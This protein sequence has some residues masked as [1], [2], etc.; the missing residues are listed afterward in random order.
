MTEAEWLTATDPE[1]MLVCVQGRSV[2]RDAVARALG[3]GGAGAEP[4]PASDR[5]LRLLACACYR[6]VPVL[7]AVEGSRRAVEAAER[8]ADS[9]PSWAEVK[10][11]AA[12]ALA[13]AKALLGQAGAERF[14][15]FDV[16]LAS[17]SLL[18]A[19]SPRAAMEAATRV[20]ARA[21]EDDWPA[22]DVDNLGATLYAVLTHH[23]P[24]RRRW[25]VGDAGLAHAALI[26][27]VCGNPFRPAPPVD[28]AWLA[29]NDATVLKLARAAYDDRVLPE[30]T[31]APAR[32]AILADA[33]ED[34][35]CADAAL[36]GHL[37]GPCVHVR[38]CWA[39]DLLLNRE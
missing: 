16:L 33:L 29:W 26:R 7:M 8:Y 27:E 38:G 13:V 4:R 22:T 30:G 32:L 34:A 19:R 12:E 9:G 1:R 28:P 21:A 25:A 2:L 15:R 18:A 23:G 5:K 31:L 11:A 24:D 17:A 39:M 3:R 35:G 14:R 37:R 10:S 6:R 36:L 20:A